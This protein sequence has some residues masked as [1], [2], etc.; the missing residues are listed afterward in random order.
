MHDIHN[1]P[2]N[3]TSYAMHLLRFHSDRELHD[4]I[5]FIYAD[6]QVMDDWKLSV[7]DYFTAIEVA[8]FYPHDV[9]LTTH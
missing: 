1:L 7:D 8:Y 6:E 9:D 4:M 2:E 5:G 3:I